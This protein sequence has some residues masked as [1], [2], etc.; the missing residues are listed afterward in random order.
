MINS[1]KYLKNNKK[2]VSKI[3]NI[4]QMNK[5]FTLILA[6]GF[7]FSAK[8]QMLFSENLTIQIDSTKTIQGML[9]P[10]IDFKTEKK[11]V[12][13]LKNT[14][15]INMLIN[16]KRVINLINKFELATY[17]DQVTLSGGYVHAEY[18]YL[19]HHAFELYPYAESQWAESR[20]MQYK[21]S[22][23]LQTRYRLLHSEKALLFAT[24]GLFYEYEKWRYSDELTP[25]MVADSRSIKTH[26]S[27]SFKYRIAE[28][29]DIITTAIHQAKPD[30][31]FDKPRY[32]GAFDLK[33]H[34][35]KNIGFRGAYRLI[36]DTNPIVPIRKNYTAVEGSIDISF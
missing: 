17:G 27:L 18:R 4:R 1:Y 19:L 36:Y 10:M 7:V 11:D 20:G 16:K 33:Y 31:N 22:S 6:M 24:A 2:G 12:L 15:N 8:G 25:E 35:T 14:A 29:W 21:I 30:S 3:L 32:G 26:F 34:I 9:S 28:K 23:G 13:T 5:L